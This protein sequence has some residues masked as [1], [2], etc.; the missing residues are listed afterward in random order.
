M[1]S[2]DYHCVSVSHLFG[3]PL[4]WSIFVYEWPRLSVTL[5]VALIGI[6]GHNTSCCTWCIVVCEL[7]E[8]EQAEPI[9]LLV[10]AVDS[11]VLFHSLISSF[12]LPITFRMITG[13]EMK[14]HVKSESERSEEV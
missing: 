6:E 9:V 1:I 3:S 12:G 8:W 14:L 13:G 4:S 10:A 2:E 7:S 5:T 11:D